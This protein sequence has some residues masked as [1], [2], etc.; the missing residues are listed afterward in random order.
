VSLAVV[1]AL[2]AT[3]AQRIR[4]RSSASVTACAVAVL[5]SAVA[6]FLAVPAGDPTAHVLLAS[7]AALSSAA[8][9]RWLLRCGT[10]CLT[11]VIIGCAMVAGV[12]AIG[13]VWRLPTN[14]MGACLAVLSLGVL[15][16]APKLAIAVTRIG[17]SPEADERDPL[18]MVAVQRDAP[19]AHRTLTGIVLG[20]A[21]CAALAVQL[22]SLQAVHGAG[23]ALGAVVFTAV[24]G[25][26]FV[27]R[28]R[29]HVVAARR[30]ILATAGLI[31]AALSFVVSA[32]S[33]PAHSHWVSIV[34]AAAAASMLCTSRDLSVHPF[35]RHAIDI[36]EYLVLAAV[37]PAAFWVGG[38]YGWV[39]D[40]GLL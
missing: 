36:A 23:S 27:L 31:L 7:S 15:A 34:A 1:F 20:S 11:A 3:A 19:V 10:V 29:T 26:A 32:V 17:P 4:P 5:F 14:L 16:V 24:V 13:A 6:G 18:D 40:T 38:I 21:A 2:V 30:I 8:L 37:V 33:A 25:L 12:A 9:F 28:V 22:I 39:R 35:A